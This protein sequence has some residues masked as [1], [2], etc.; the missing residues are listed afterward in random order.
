MAKILTLMFFRFLIRT[1]N[2]YI[3]P[4]VFDIGHAPM[5]KERS[6]VKK[7]LKKTI[8]KPVNDKFS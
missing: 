7:Y 5:A 1:Y 8:I 2:V 4:L 6:L 3:G